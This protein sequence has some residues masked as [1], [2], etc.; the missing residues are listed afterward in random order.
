MHYFRKLINTP[1]AMLAIAILIVI[2]LGISTVETVNRNWELQQKINR[3]QEE[4]ELIDLENEALG[5]DIEYYKTDE[6]LELAAKQDLGLRAPGEKV[7]VLPKSQKPTSD[8][9]TAEPELTGLEQAME[10][11]QAWWNFLFP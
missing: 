2:Y 5:Y 8:K 11:W 4:N 3:L 10:N 7:I 9:S 1:H 6:Y